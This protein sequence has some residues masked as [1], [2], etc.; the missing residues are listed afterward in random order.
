MSELE[1]CPA[2]DGTGKMSIKFMEFSSKGVKT[3]PPVAIDCIW[4]KGIGTV[5]KKQL[6]EM[7][8]YAKMWCKCDNPSEEADLSEDGEHPDL[9][10]HHW[11]CSNCGK[12]KQIG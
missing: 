10:K 9:I 3:N 4:C 12:V 1:K 7:E 5:D 8:S 2:C 11:R 6:A